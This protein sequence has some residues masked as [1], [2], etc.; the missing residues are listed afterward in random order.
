M[1]NSE[2][3]IYVK[4]I[5]LTLEDYNWIKENKGKKSAA[6]FLKE[7]INFYKNDK[8]KPITKAS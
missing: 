3:T 7:I 6:G 5:R 2:T 1:R 4:G 8:R